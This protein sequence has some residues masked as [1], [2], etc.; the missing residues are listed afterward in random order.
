MGSYFTPFYSIKLLCHHPC[1]M[2]ISGVAPPLDRIG[3]RS[4]FREARD[5]LG[6]FCNPEGIHMSVTSGCPTIRTEPKSE[7][8]IAPFP[9]MSLYRQSIRNQVTATAPGASA[10][11][12]VWIERGWTDAVA[13][14]PVKRERQRPRLAALPTRHHS[15]RRDTDA[16]RRQSRRLPLG[17]RS[18]SD[19]SACFPIPQPSRGL[20]LCSGRLYWLRR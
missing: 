14:I 7:H 13:S 19:S 18:P 17:G 5:S 16:K 11:V 9:A 12:P 4:S 15:P 1:P 3:S 10:L 20:W 8:P 6:T 2:T